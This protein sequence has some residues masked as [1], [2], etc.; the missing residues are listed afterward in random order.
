MSELKSKES[1]HNKYQIVCF[2]SDKVIV[3][4]HWKFVSSNIRIFVLYR[5]V[6]VCM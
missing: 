6:D 5:Y 4:V 1:T 2:Y 3:Y